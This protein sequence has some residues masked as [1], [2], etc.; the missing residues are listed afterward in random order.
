M[1]GEGAPA[2][3]DRVARPGWRNLATFDTFVQSTLRTPISI[4]RRR[5]RPL[6]RQIYDEWR[7]G[8][9][10]GRFGPGDTFNHPGAEFF[11]TFRNSLFHRIGHKGCHHGPAARQ[12][13]KEKT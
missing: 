1:E 2:M 8:I 4:D 11:R 13:P 5:Q 7:R 12:H 9:L 10:S 6:H 3:P